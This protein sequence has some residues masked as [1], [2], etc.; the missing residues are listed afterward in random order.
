MPR[1]PPPPPEPNSLEAWFA[2]RSPELKLSAFQRVYLAHLEKLARRQL[3]KRRMCAMMPPGHAKTTLGTL[4]FV[5]W[6]L[7]ENPTH[8]V[9]ILSYDDSYAQEL[10]GAVRNTCVAS[11]EE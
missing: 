9:L 1:K 11:G 10:G 6:Y 8:N 3:P 2:A 7:K 4:E 5:P